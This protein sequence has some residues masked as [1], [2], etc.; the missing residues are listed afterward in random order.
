MTKWD[1]RAAMIKV[2]GCVLWMISLVV[3]LGASLVVHRATVKLYAMM[4]PNPWTISFV[5]KVVIIQTTRIMVILGWIILGLLGELYFCQ[6]SDL[7]K[8]LRRF[9]FVLVPASIVVAVGYT[10]GLIG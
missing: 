9:A 1:P 7:G 4:L 8:L 5:D 6:V 3:G 2:V 10:L